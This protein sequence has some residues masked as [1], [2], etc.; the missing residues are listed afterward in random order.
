MPHGKIMMSILSWFPSSFPIVYYLSGKL[1]KLLHCFKKVM[2]FGVSPQFYTDFGYFVTLFY[3]QVSWNTY[4][5][6]CGGEGI[7]NGCWEVKN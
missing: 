3:L 7:C 4:I 2:K 1:V 6:V 5:L